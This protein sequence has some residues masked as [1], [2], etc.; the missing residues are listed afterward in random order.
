[1]KTK[2]EFEMYN[3]D[4]FNKLAYIRIGAKLIHPLDANCKMIKRICLKTCN[5]TIM[6]NI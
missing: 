1:M 2:P 3:L 6:I 4:K 5:N